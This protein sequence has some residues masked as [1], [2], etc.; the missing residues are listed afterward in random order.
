MTRAGQR[1]RGLIRHEHAD[2][3]APRL[4]DVS[5][6]PAEPLISAITLAELSVGHGSDGVTLTGLVAFDRF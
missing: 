6:L 2:P 5:V 1:P 3:P 4:S